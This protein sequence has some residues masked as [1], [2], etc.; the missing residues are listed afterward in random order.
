MLIGLRIVLGLLTL[1]TISL[2]TYSLLLII[3]YLPHT[4][5]LLSAVPLFF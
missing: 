2:C 3:S 1:L 4:Y 5:N